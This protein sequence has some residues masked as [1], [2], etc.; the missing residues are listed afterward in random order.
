MLEME[1][2]R[3]RENRERERN[4]SEERE[5]QMR[6]LSSQSTFPTQPHFEQYYSDSGAPPHAM[7]KFPDEEQLRSHVLYLITRIAVTTLYSPG[8]ACI[9]K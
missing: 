2:S 4:V 3:H 8:V 7:Y 1:E 6:M 9:S 5:F